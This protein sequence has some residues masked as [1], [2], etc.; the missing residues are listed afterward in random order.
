MNLISV[1]NLYFYMTF[2]ILIL[3]VMMK[4]SSSFF[5][6]RTRYNE[7]WKF[8]KYAKEPFRKAAKHFVEVS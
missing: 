8:L 2:N 7:C 5:K 3:L 6:H 1:A 4:V